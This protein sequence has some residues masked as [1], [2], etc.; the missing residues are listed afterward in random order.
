MNLSYIVKKRLL[1]AVSGWGLFGFYRGIQDYHYTHYKKMEEYNQDI[2]KYKKNMAE[3]GR[4]HITYPIPTFFKPQKFFITELL[5]GVKGFLCYFYPV[6]G[7]FFFIKEIYIAEIYLRNL[8][9][10][11]KTDYYN[12]LTLF[13]G[14]RIG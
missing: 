3:Y 14:T 10:Q 9:D 12:S 8:E 11:K 2:E 6:P 13:D 4:Y 5:Y 1:L 7:I